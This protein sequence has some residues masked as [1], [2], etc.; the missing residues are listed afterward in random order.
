MHH[1][2]D[3]W[4][5]I[6]QVQALH[7][8]KLTLGCELLSQLPHYHIVQKYCQAKLS[9]FESVFLTFL[10][11]FTFLNHTHYVPLFII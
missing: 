7:R 10:L 9:K 8:F 2:F 5:T 1:L 11:V 3:V 4:L 6:L